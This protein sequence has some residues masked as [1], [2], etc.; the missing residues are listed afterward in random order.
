MSKFDESLYELLANNI[1]IDAMRGGKKK[2][3]EVLIK[4][5]SETSVSTFERR[6]VVWLKEATLYALGADPDKC[7]GEFK[8]Q[9]EDRTLEATN[10]V[11]FCDKA[12]HLSE[13]CDE[14]A[15]R[16]AWRKLLRKLGNARLFSLQ[17]AEDFN[18]I[19][20][21]DYHGEEEDD[22]FDDEKR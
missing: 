22:D 1:V 20:V 2:E 8:L 9:L 16:T 3:L 12:F 6:M 17:I 14:K 21:D 11:V 13:N 15:W 5:E 19:Y 18:D 4:Q 10:A 7:D